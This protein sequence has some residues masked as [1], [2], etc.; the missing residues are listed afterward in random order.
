MFHPYFK[1]T[2]LDESNFSKPTHRVSWSRSLT[3]QSCPSKLEEVIDTNNLI[4]RSKAPHTLQDPF[5]LIMEN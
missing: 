5:F 2:K 4:S 1:L 3:Y